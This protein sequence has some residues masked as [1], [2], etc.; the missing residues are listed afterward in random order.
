MSERS[1]IEALLFYHRPMSDYRTVVVIF[2]RIKGGKSHFY[3]TKKGPE[4]PFLPTSW[5]PIG[6][7]VTPKDEEL[8][9]VLR[10]EFGDMAPD[11]LN[12][13]TALRLVFERNLFN[14]KKII[15]L[16]THDN[17]HDLISIIEPEILN[18]WF[19]SMVP[20]GFQRLQSGE[21]TF[22]TNYF[23]FITPSDSKFRNMK[24]K[25][26][27]SVSVY[28]GLLMEEK[29]KWFEAE[30]IQKQYHNL[31]KLFSP[32]IAIL[33][34]K[35]TKEYKKPFEAA[36]EMEQKKGVSPRIS[37]Q[38]F[39]YT[40][41]FS[42]PSPALPPYNTT[43]IYVIGNEKK[44][45]IDPGSNEF[46]ATKDLNIFIEKNEDTMEGILITN[47]FPDHCNQAL[48][49]KDTFG[50][51][52]FT[53]VKNAKI[54]EQEGFDFHSILEEGTKIHLGSNPELNKESW[55]LETIDLPGSSE[56]SIGLWDSR[57]LL[58]SGISLHKGLTTTN[59]SYPESYSEF[60]SSLKKMKK[61]NANFIL[62]GHGYI[63]T[64]ANKTLSSN[65]QR[66]KKIKKKLTE[67]LKQGIS[68][69]DSLTDI[70]TTK[71]TV[72]WRFYMKRIVLSV[73]EHLVIK[74]RITKI[75]SDYIWKKNNNS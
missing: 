12:R 18:V 27:S 40:W 65:K 20:C 71:D 15:D 45:I 75:G 37:F 74:G 1:Y 11:M 66:I 36:R 22:N 44:Y 19:H 56:G 23:L 35:I 60:L 5:S 38:L 57:G 69:I 13:L 30:E 61:L 25:R 2:F 67:A 28:P 47:P 16:K 58:F 55:N 8:C 50:L 68:E 7:L 48:Y 54:L 14:I 31:D 62:S 39:P 4:L 41:R 24:L 52:M 10:G 42:T 32:S 3:L 43:N 46:E 29:A 73:L 49:F 51:P 59:A 53:S 21:N 72:E 26:T 64:D 63:I 34:K 70:I 17:E 6:S 9:S 33:T